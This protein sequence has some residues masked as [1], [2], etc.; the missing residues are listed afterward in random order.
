LTS[1]RDFGRVVVVFGC[2]REGDTEWH[3]GGWVEEDEEEG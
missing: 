3:G 2:A 1:G